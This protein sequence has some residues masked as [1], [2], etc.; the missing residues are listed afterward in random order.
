MSLLDLIGLNRIFKDGVPINPT[1]KVLN[2]IGVGIT[3][4]DNPEHDRT[5][6]TIA[7]T[8]GGG[9]EGTITGPE[10]TVA[11]HIATWGNTDGTE[12]DDSGITL[13]ELATE[14]Y[15]DAA[16]DALPV[17]GD[18]VGPSGAVDDRIATFDGVTGKLLQD[19]GKS[20][21]AVTSDAAA[22]ALL[23]VDTPAAYNGHAT[24]ASTI[25]TATTWSALLTILSGGTFVD[26]LL[27]G[28]SRSGSTFTVAA[29]GYYHFH[30]SVNVYASNNS[31]PLRVRRAGV[32]V[33]AQSVYNPPGPVPSVPH[34]S[35]IVLAA[36]G[37]SFTF[38]YMR[39]PTGSAGTF[40]AFPQDG[41]SQ[42]N[43]EISIFR[44]GASTVPAPVVGA[45][46]SA[47]ARGR[48]RSDR[49]A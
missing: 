26:T 36:A 25:N 20:I 31:T 6:I 37:D 17:G 19:G 33:L 46:G 30:A 38:E 44:I 42:R 27:Q 41:E 28:I 21:A 1:R 48:P 34:V 8:G 47:R 2:L 10:T 24:G 4:V 18:V 45:G 13:A 15:V 5:D 16:I 49:I 39:E 14:D 40:G 23:A 32:T 7:G 3:V 29:A 22:A 11:G 12:L 9:G 43:M 35:G